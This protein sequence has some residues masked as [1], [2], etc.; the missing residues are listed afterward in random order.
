MNKRKAFRIAKWLGWHK[1]LAFGEPDRTNGR[2]IGWYAHKDTGQFFLPDS[3]HK[4][5][6][7]WD[8]SHTAEEF[9][10]L[11]REL[12]LRRISFYISFKGDRCHA[13]MQGYN[14]I[15]DSQLGGVELT[16]GLAY[17]HGY[18]NNQRKALVEALDEL[19]SYERRPGNVLKGW[20]SS[21][22]IS[23]GRPQ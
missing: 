14:N 8:P 5:Y 17:S 6:D 20:E 22:L 2:M 9:D 11:L 13:V 12:S 23:E 21:R 15:R 18:G 7:D 19:I 1:H 10:I 4:A 16:A 3:E